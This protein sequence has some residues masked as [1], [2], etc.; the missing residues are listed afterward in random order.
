[1]VGRGW[2][3]E[4]VKGTQRHGRQLS[5]AGKAANSKLKLKKPKLK[6]KWVLPPSGVGCNHKTPRL[7]GKGGKEVKWEERRGRIKS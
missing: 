3:S 1:M 2:E 5:Q 7:E 6:K 4:K